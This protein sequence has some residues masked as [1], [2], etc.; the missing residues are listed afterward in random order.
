MIDNP[1][2]SCYNNLKEGYTY[3]NVAEKILDIPSDIPVGEDVRYSCPGFVLL[4]KLLEKIFERPLNECFDDLVAKPLHLFDTSFVPKDRKG[5]VNAN[6]D[7]Q[8]CGVVND[9]NCR[10]LGGVAGNAGLFSNLSDV[11]GYVKLLLNRGQPLF[12]KSI[13]DLATRN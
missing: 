6:M 5:A 12:S 10:F 13:F 9:Y 11:T 7:E 8:F 1:S 2:L 3:A 4:G